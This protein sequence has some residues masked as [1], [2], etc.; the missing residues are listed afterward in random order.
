MDKNIPLKIT[1]FDPSICTG[2]LGDSIIMDCARKQ[3]KKIFP[4]AYLMNVQTHDIIGDASYKVINSS[5]YSIVCGTNL[6]S[7]NMN[8]YNQW[9]INLIDSLKLKNIILM[10]VG[11]WQYQPNPNFYTRYLLRKILHNRLFHSVRD[12]YAF[13]KLNLSGINNVINTGCVTLWDL[14]PQHIGSIPD[15]K[16]DEVVMTFTDYNQR[17]ELDEQLYKLLLNNYRKIYF[18]IQGSRDYEY[19]R[20]IVSENHVEFID[21]Y[22]DAFDHLLASSQSLDYVGTRLHAGI[23][24][25]QFKRRTIILSVD[26]RAREKG[27]DFSLPVIDRSDI[28]G[29]A[30]MIN[31]PLNIKKLDVPYESIQRWKQ[32]FALRK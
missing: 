3:I 27:A 4:R 15:E 30:R 10:G 28:D 23:R 7:S 26:N 11:W 24:A 18:W 6:L 29:I 14:T 32:Q 17:P 22:L 13:N 20:K 12:N 9:K 5:D 19:A 25:L 16:G 2:N 31:N 8:K 1:L 21:P